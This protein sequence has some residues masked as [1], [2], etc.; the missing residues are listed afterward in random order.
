VAASYRTLWISDVHL[1]NNASQANDLLNFLTEVRA[2]RTYLVGD[3]VDLERLKRRPCFAETHLRVIAELVRLASQ[4]TEV[5]YIPGNH[6][7][8]FRSWAGRDIC[9][10]P[11]ALEAIHETATGRKLL[12]MHGDVLDRQIRQGT[13]LEKFGATAYLLLMEANTI[14]NRI[15][16]RLGQDYFPLMAGI[17]R[18]LRGANAYIERFEEVAAEYAAGRGFDGVVCGHIHRPGIRMINGCLYF[19]DGDWVEH[20]TALAESGDGSMQILNWQKDAVSVEVLGET[21]PLAA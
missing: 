4:G 11:V 10:I 19:N 3:I 20:R 5:I 8:Q 18:R 6:D 13:G 12:V 16:R 2:D 1:G 9:G 14:I 21:T 7:F 17:K 15:R